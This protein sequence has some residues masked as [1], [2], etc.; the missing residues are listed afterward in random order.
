MMAAFVFG[1]DTHTALSL[2]RAFVLLLDRLELMQIYCRLLFLL[3]NA[4]HLP[5]IEPLFEVCSLEEL[6]VG[7]GVV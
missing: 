3:E 5:L 7:E 1:G 2:T 4:I 6:H